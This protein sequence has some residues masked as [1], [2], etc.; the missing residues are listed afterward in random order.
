MSFFEG[1]VGITALELNEISFA[2]IV[3]STFNAS[4]YDSHYLT[5]LA[6]DTGDLDHIFLDGFKM[7]VS[8]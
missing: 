6:E 2:V 1:V 5:H 3:R 4:S 7:E 8:V